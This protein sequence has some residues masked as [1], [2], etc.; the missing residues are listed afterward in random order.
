M[1]GEK[2]TEEKREEKKTT[3]NIEQCRWYR[4][5]FVKSS[6]SFLKKIFVQQGG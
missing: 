1:V 2:I 4:E 3:Q 5:H 6:G